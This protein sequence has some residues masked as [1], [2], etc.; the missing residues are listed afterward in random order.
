MQGIIAWNIHSGSGNKAGVFKF[1]WREERFQKAPFRDRGTCLVTYLFR[2]IR[3][4]LLGMQGIIAW[5]IH[6]ESGNKASVFKFLWSVACVA[7]VSVQFGSKEV[8]SDKWNGQNAE[9]PVLRS[10]LNLVPRAHV[11]WCWPK[12]TWALGTRM[13]F[14]PWKRLLRRLSGVKRVFRTLCFVTE[15]LVSWHTGRGTWANA[16]DNAR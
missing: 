14:A 3:V 4:V 9:N 10:L 2:D 12:G 15:E 13:L 6:S 8:Q 16:A 5:N 1:L 7:S 11:S